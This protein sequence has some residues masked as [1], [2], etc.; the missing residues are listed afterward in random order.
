MEQSLYC[1]ELR[2]FLLF[3][4]PSHPAPITHLLWPWQSAHIQTHIQHNTWIQAF[5]VC[6]CVWRRLH[7]FRDGICF[8]PQVFTSTTY[9]SYRSR[10]WRS[11]QGLRQILTFLFPRSPVLNL[12]LCS[13]LAAL[14][15]VADLVNTFFSLLWYRVACPAVPNFEVLLKLQLIALY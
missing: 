7:A 4:P 2:L 10:T 6:V 14:L 8:H 13:F 15:L 11:S 5:T 9:S 1:T 3:L 12:L